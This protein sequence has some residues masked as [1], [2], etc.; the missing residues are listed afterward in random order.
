MAVAEEG[1]MSRA[2]ERLNYVQSNVTARIHQLEENL[3][4]SLFYRKSRGVALT[5]V[6]HFFLEYANRILSLCDEAINAVQEESGPTGTLTIGAMEATAVVHLPPILSSYQ[7][8]YPAV[9]LKLFTGTSEQMLACLLEYRADAV[10][11][12]C[13]VDHPDLSADLM[14]LEELVLAAAKNKSPFGSKERQN[15]LVFRKGCAFRARLEM[16]LRES[17]LLPYRIMEFS[18]VESILGC[19]LAGM[20]IT[21]LPR[22]VFS[23]GRYD[24]EIDIYPLPE[25]VA[26]LPVSFVKRKDSVKSKALEAFHDEVRLWKEQKPKL[27][28]KRSK[29]NNDKNALD[30]MPRFDLR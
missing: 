1:S 10:F 7:S 4:V 12:G 13:Q 15:I 21:F 2:A 8:K 5:P 16:W 9:D 14:L 29:R 6:G 26:L 20:G 11:T 30:R 27:S 19:V 25:K 3:N 28:H 18:S 24:S 23:S 22:S 17:N